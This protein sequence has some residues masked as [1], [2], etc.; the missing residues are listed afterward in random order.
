MLK[1]IYK[2]RN[3]ETLIYPIINNI[4]YHCSIPKGY[5][6]VIYEYRSSWKMTQADVENSEFEGHLSTIFFNI[7]IFI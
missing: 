2:K 5:S 1:I 7:V 3:I 4:I 6:Q